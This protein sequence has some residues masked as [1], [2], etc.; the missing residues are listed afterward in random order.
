M[1]KSVTSCT[2]GPIQ[3]GVDVMGKQTTLG[4]RQLFAIEIARAVSVEMAH[5]NKG[6]YHTMWRS[7]DFKKVPRNSGKMKMVASFSEHLQR[8]IVIEVTFTSRPGATEESASVIVTRLDPQSGERLAGYTAVAYE[9]GEHGAKLYH[10]T[11][12]M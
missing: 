12:I 8:K 7:L 6:D 11:H 10:W 5:A 9:R 2:T 4:H 1:A 3:H